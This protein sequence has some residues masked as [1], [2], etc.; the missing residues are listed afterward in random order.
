MV[1]FVYADTSVFKLGVLNVS[2]NILVTGKK[3]DEKI[4][5]HSGNC[6]NLRW[7]KGDGCTSPVSLYEGWKS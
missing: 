3:F 1:H 4:L 5:S 7:G 6:K 2:W